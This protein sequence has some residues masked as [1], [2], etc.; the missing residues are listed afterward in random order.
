M[1]TSFP[2]RGAQLALALALGVSLSA[3]GESRGTIGD[4]FGGARPAEDVTRTLP[5]P[6]PDS[7]GVITYA[8]YQVM[9][10]QD[11]DDVARMAQRVGLDAQ[12]LA[13]HNG[14]PVTYRPRAGEVIALPRDVGGTPATV[15]SVTAGPVTGGVWSADIAASAIESAPL[16]SAAPAATPGVQGENPFNNG[17]STTVIDPTRHRVQAGETAYSIARTYGVSIGALAAWNGLGS[18]MTVRVNQELL[19]PVADTR[20]RAAASQPAPAPAAQAAQPAPQ[21]AQQPAQQAAAPQPERVAAANPPGTSTPILPPPSAANP[22]PADQDIDDAPPPPSP[23]LAAQ[24]SADAM[25]AMPVA[26]GGVLRGYNPDGGTKRNEGIDFSAA[27][28][29]PVRAASDGEVALISESL[30]GL[31]TIVLIRHEGN[32]MT[33]YGRVTDV[34]LSKGDKVS[35]GQQ[36]GSVA[37]GDQPNLHFEVRRGTDSVDPGPFLGL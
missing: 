8:N 2:K 22:L 7:R 18:D 4:M 34:S 19:I 15:E 31:G 21:P 29:A 13:R 33:V 28:G 12:E 36:I 26:A 9:V 3:C 32:M 14:L 35:R 16:G 24:R 1:M 27:A 30:G 23:N 25:L 11:G 6:Q 20:L 10:A 5:R 37:A 17:Q